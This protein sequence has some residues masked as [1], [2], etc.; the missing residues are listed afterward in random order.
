MKHLICKQISIFAHRRRRAQQAQWIFR[1]N[2]G[3][4]ISSVPL[5]WSDSSNGGKK[6]KTQRE[7]DFAKTIT[8]N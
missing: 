8:V 6:K 1:K 2:S 4:V 3:L 7:E 5:H